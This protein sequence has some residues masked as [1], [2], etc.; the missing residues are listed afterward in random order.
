[1]SQDLACT[2]RLQTWHQ[3][4]KN[5]QEASAPAFL[6]DIVVRKVT[7]KT[8]IS[9]TPA[10]IQRGTF[11]PRLPGRRRTKDIADFDLDRLAQATNGN[12][13]LLRYQSLRQPHPSLFV[14]PDLSD[15]QLVTEV[16]AVSAPAPVLTVEAAFKKSSCF[17]DFV[18]HLQA[19][20]EGVANVA[21]RT[22]EQTSS[23]MWQTYRCGRVTSSR[24]T[25]CTNKISQNS[26]LTTAKTHSIVAD[27]MGY[28]EEAVGPQ[29]SWGKSREDRARKLYVITQRKIHKHLDVALTGVWISSKTPWVAASPDGLVSCTCCGSGCLEIKCPWTHRMLSVAQY[30]Q[31]TDAC[32]S[33]SQITGDFKLKKDHA[34]FGQVQL[35]MYCTETYWCD[36]V[37]HTAAK[38]GNLATLRVPRDDEYIQHQT[39]KSRI[40]LE[41]CIYSEL[42]TRQ[43]KERVREN[44]VK[45]VMEDI[46]K[47][48][49]SIGTTQSS[50]T[51][52]LCGACA[53]TWSSGDESIQCESCLMWFHYK[54]QGIKGS[55][56]FLKNDDSWRCSFCN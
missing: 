56:A 16:T 17:E 44:Y 1:V 47:Q 26:L 50:N 41:F 15:V 13:A 45:R 10:R 39:S 42:K 27:V 8:D 54:C 30:A 37:V 55:E 34:Y 7:S 18:V 4:S 14:E 32:L 21:S 38:E 29:L 31:Q 12:C 11:D 3:P 23:Q 40:F 48:L 35:H 25:K 33:F 24:V 22:A 6:K 52:F 36:F 46:L 20:P 43:V 19:S 5:A 51:D 49:D 9:E 53:S 28:Y 2:S